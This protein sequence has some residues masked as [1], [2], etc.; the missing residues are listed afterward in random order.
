MRIQSIS[1]LVYAAWDPW[2]KACSSTRCPREPRYPQVWKS[3]FPVQI[4][5]LR[6]FSI[7]IISF[8]PW[9]QYPVDGSH[10]AALTYDVDTMD[11]LRVIQ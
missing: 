5:A 11:G 2:S 7:D 4:C 6:Q 1:G 10:R 9:M 8:M 3:P